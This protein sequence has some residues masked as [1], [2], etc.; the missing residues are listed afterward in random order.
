[1]AGNLLAPIYTGGLLQA[2]V[3]TADENQKAALALYGQTILQAFD[4]VEVTLTNERYLKDEAKDAQGALNSIQDALTLGRVKYDVGQT[5]LS[6]VL[7]LENVVL[8]TEMATTTIQYDL[9][10]NRIDLY[11][12]LGGPF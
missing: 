8:G 9:I 5:D 12:A 2:R 4:D 6:P 7:Q 1:V 10:A 3:K 11:L